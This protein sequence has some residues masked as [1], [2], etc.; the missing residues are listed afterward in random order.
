MKQAIVMFITIF[1]LAGAALAENYS[2]TILHTNDTHTRLAAAEEG[3]AWGGAARMATLIEQERMLSENVLLLDAGDWSERTFFHNI[4]GSG[5]LE[6]RLRNEEYLDYDAVVIGNHDYLYRPDFLEDKLASESPTYPV[7]LSNVDFHGYGN[8]DS[9]VEEYVIFNFA[10]FKVG[11]FGLTTETF[12]YTLFFEPVEV[13]NPEE[14]AEE[15]VS[16]LEGEGVDIIICLSHLGFN[17]SGEYSDMDLASDVAGIDLIVGGHSHTVLEEAVE[18]ENPLGEITW[19]VQAW[20]FYRCLGRVDLTYNSNTGET[21]LDDSQLI[22]TLPEVEEDADVKALVEEQI[23]AINEK[24][25]YPFDDAIC[26]S[27]IDLFVRNTES[28]M[29]NLY[30]DIF[31]ESLNSNGYDADAVLVTDN[32][33]AENIDVGIIN[34]SNAYESF[35][36]GYDPYTDEN[37]K[38]W[39]CEVQGTN[40]KTVF[41]LS[42]L[43]GYYFNN[44]GMEIIIDPNAGSE[45][46]ISFLING[47]ELQDDEWYKIGVNWAEYF[48]LDNNPL[49]EFYPIEIQNPLETEI[50]C[51]RAVRDWYQDAGVVT[52][53]DARINGRFRTVQPDLTIFRE[54]IAFFPP[55]TALIGEK[56]KINI[57]VRNF[58]ESDAAGAK[59]KVYFE[60]TPN[61]IL[62]DPQ[63]SSSTLIYEEKLPAVEAFGGAVFERA[64]YWNTLQ[65]SEEGKYRIYTILEKVV[66]SGGEQEFNTRNNFNPSLS[67]G[68][69]LVEDTLELGVQLIMP[70]N[71]YYEGDDCWVNA[72]ISNP[73]DP[74]EDVPLFVIL[75]VYGELFFWPSWTSYGA[76]GM[77]DYREIDLGTGTMELLILQTFG[78][79]ALVEDLPDLYFHGAMV[80]MEA[81][82]L[83]GELDSI[84]FDILAD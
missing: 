9:L 5:S 74:M 70:S 24:Y 81:A 67:K 56:V 62:D 52:S 57:K 25:D 31:L 73:G 60:E 84:E 34:S 12:L 48:I 77:I 37:L 3:T 82:M 11:L 76:T 78:M 32:F 42:T 15:M 75:D 14:K 65:V 30:A 13:T 28:N 83:I 61:N 20:E 18:V 46:F 59:L 68:Y 29:G 64:V 10:D 27:Y 72:V 21:L 41:G 35:P 44:S 54:D 23:E 38:L 36:Y 45:S 4:A 58:G 69:N 40:L 51:W 80:D 63:Y 19:V 26:E 7:L 53:A 39:S 16:F 47:E 71:H 33:M 43:M 22:F 49:S 2:L 66:D 8:L 1:C 55:Q 17:S 79:P 6:L 50:E